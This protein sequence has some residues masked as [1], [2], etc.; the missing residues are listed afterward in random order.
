MRTGMPLES[1]LDRPKSLTDLA[2]ER[3]RK[4]IVEGERSF[5]EPLSE[6]SLAL[7]LGI[8]KTP[9][10]EALLRLKM[11]GLVDIQPQ[12]GT[13]VF[14]MEPHE[15]RELTAFRE[16]IETEALALAMRRK[17]GALVE[18][19]KANLARMPRRVDDQ[20]RVHALDTEFHDTIVNACGNRYLLAA[21]AL[22]GH[23]VEALRYRLPVGNEEVEHCQRNHARIVARIAEGDVRRAQT[24]LREHIRSTEESYLAA[25]RLAAK[26][27]R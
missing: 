1:K 4:T 25:S 26:P 17:R 8:S 19:L 18:A 9:V 6:A 12:R 5:G 21:Y 27:P 13:F 20:R 14:S 7:G 23:R 16:V 2:V 10:R 15:V 3:I 11:D 24:M 22:I